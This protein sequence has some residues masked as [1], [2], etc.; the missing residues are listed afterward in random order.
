[1]SQINIKNIPSEL[2][3][4]FD[5]AAAMQGKTRSELII[6]LMSQTVGDASEM[7]IAY[8][9]VAYL[10]DVN[11]D[12]DIC[13]FCDENTLSADAHLAHYANG[14]IA[15]VCGVCAESHDG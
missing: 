1:M 2:L 9:K 6:D 7:V 13:P 3:A 4:K 8:T 15:L 11:A 14:Q 10:G 12:E 5:L